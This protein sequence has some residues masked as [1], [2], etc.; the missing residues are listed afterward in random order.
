MTSQIYCT[1]P[2]HG[3]L[4]FYLLHK[5]TSYYLFRQPY[6][7]RVYLFYSRPVLLN[8]ALSYSRAKGNNQIRKTISRLPGAIHYIEF[9]Y[10]ITV[11][12]RTMKRKNIAA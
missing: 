6:R 8:D 4:H 11:L 10:G 2:Q 12:K 5:G 7:G 9:E 1:N 3:E